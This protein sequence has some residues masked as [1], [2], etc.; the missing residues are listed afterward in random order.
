[1]DGLGN[2]IVLMLTGGEVHDSVMMQP[3]LNELT[4]EGSTVLADKAYGSKSNREYISENG[5]DYCIPPKSNTK[6]PWECDYSHYKERHLVE[7]F[8]MKIKDY[9][10]VAMRFEKLARRYIAFVFLA[11]VMV[12]LA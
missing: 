5:A 11:A 6:E 9:R 2:P 10:R 8:F 1:M 4:I 3:A 12:W 7:C